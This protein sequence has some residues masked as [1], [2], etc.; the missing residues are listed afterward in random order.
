MFFSLPSE[1][2]K[3]IYEYDST[4]REQYDKVMEN[5]EQY[6]IYH[7]KRN[8]QLYFIHDNKKNNGYVTN[9]LQTPTW[10]STSHNVYLED[11]KNLNLIREK[12]KT[13]EYDIESFC[14]GTDNELRFL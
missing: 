10:I 9:S 1:L 3:E 7:F 6:Q 5:I 2:I 14:F 8:D 13:L 4:Y 11:L 12:N